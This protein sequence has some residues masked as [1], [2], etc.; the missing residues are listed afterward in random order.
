MQYE[1]REVNTLDE[2]NALGA[3]GWKMHHRTQGAE[4]TIYVMERETKKEAKAD[5]KKDK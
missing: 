1:Y 4:R 2:V 5:S 3:D